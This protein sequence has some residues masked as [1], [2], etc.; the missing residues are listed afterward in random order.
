MSSYFALN[1]QTIHSS[2]GLQRRAV[3]VL[4]TDALA[5]GGA[6][7]ESNRRLI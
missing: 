1:V 5:R 3:I 7:E 2:K 6:L 4:W